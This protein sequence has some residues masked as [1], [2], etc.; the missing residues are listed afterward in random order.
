[1]ALAS[2]LHPWWAEMTTRRLTEPAPPRRLFL[3]TAAL[4]L[5]LTPAVLSAQPRPS[6]GGEVPYGWPE[7][8]R[9]F[10]QDGPA[11]LLGAEQRAEL[12]AAPDAERAAFIDAFLSADPLPET[13]ENELLQ[14]IEARRRLVRE[15]LPTF[16]DDR[17][18]LLFLHGVPRE[19]LVVDCGSVYRPLEVWSYGDPD[20]EEVAAAGRPAGGAPRVVLYR[21]ATGEPFRVWEPVDAKRAL[22]VSGME[23]LLEQ[24][25]ELRGY[26]T[27]RRPDLQLCEETRRVEEATGIRAL[28]MYR[29]ERPRGE[30][31]LY[32]LQPP[33]DLATWAR[34]AAATPL[35]PPPPEL[36]V[37]SA[38]VY[39]P[40]R[41]GQRLVGQV[42]L[43]LPAGAGFETTEPEVR[44]EPGME[45]A[46]TQLRLR[47]EGVIE[48]GGQVFDDVRVRFRPPPPVEGEPVVLVFDRSLRPQLSYLLRLTVVDEVGEAQTHLDLA[49]RV[50]PEPRPGEVPVAQRR[51]SGEDLAPKRVIGED[52][53]VLLPPAGETVV[54]LWRAN[55]LVTGERIERVVFLVDGERQLESRQRPFS[56]ELRLAQFPKEQVV[57]AEGYD[58]QGHLVEVDEVVINRPR[59]VFR[60]RVVEPPE[61]F[62]SDGGPVRTLVDVSVPEEK[63]LDRVELRLGDELVA[64]LE[65]PP[66]E[67][68]VDVP[69][70][71]E[72]SFLTVNAFLE[73]GTGTEAVRILNAGPGF[74]EQVEVQLVE[75]YVT[76]QDGGGRLVRGLGRDDFVVLDDGVEQEIRRFELVDALPLTVGIVLDVSGSMATS[77]SEAQRAGIAFLDQVVGPGDR[78]FAV[79]FS[80]VPRLLMPPTDDVDV[81]ADALAAQRAAGRTTLHDGVITALSYLREVEGQQALVLLS[82]GDD[83]A[84]SFDFDEALEYARRSEAAVYAIGLN[85]PAA[86]FGVRNKLKKLAGESGGRSFFISKAE[87][88]V[89]VYGEIE[90]ELRSRYFLAY[91]PQPPPEP[92]SGFREV[93]VRVKKRGVET[94]TVRGYYP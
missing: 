22:Y 31:Y 53:L 39:F 89:D 16:N 17:A 44:G 38:R 33:R 58:S 61:G 21:P 26:I 67:A 10:F 47:V 13:P 42:H 43:T 35:P 45:G 20:A 40:R 1:M 63:R 94:R 88:L 5:L 75:L 14:G 12:L 2:T 77:L 91:A 84:S 37:E 19:R 4:L 11:L 49:F 8:Q 74:S 69:P 25:E 80:D 82:D 86:S 28:T 15:S 71:G 72:L 50:P 24:W 18:R 52:N 9:A 87:E 64:T 81:V 57:R 70:G 59:D 7:E 73:D 79:A 76:A 92:G 30:E 78:A 68:T 93:T 51:V 48:Q 60:V 46:E 34:Q 66:F 41:D 85:I 23:Y 32:W 6:A 62:V 55:A 90:E 27:G 3:V 65:E 54:G 56:A 83:T 36:E 29:R